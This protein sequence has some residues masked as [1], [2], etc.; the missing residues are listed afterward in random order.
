MK[1]VLLM[2]SLILFFFGC[3]VDQTE[4]NRVIKERDDLATKVN[5]DAAVIQ[6][7]RDSIIML[8]FPADQRLVHDAA[9]YYRREQAHH[10]GQQYGYEH[11]NELE[12]VRL[13]IAQYP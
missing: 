8:S 10:S 7:L 12:P 6:V 5:E 4:F 13:Q 11:E 3:G 9:C 1:R 2:T